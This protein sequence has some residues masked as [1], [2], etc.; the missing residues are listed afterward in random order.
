[1][2]GVPRER[3][4]ISSAPSGSSSTPRI[5]R[6]PPQDRGELVGVVVV[7]AGD[8]AEAVAQRTGDEPGARGG[9]DEREARQVEAD[10]ARARALADHDVEAE[11]LHRGIE[12]L[13][14]DAR[15][16]VHLVD[17]QHVA[18]V[19]V[20]E[21][22][23][24]VAGPLERGTA[25]GLMRAPISF[26][27]IPASVVL[28]RPGGPASST[29]STACP[30]CLAA[31]EHDLEVL[32]QARLADELVETARPQRGLFGDLAGSASGLEQL[33]SHAQRPHRQQHRSA[34]R[35]SSSTVPSSRQLAEHVADLVG[36]VAE[37]DERVA[38]LG[39]RR[40]AGQ[41]RAS[42]ARSRSGTSSRAFRSTS[43]RCAVRLPTP[44]TST[45][46]VEVVVGQA[47]AQRRRRVHRQDRERELRADAARGDQRL[48]RVALVA[49]RE[50]EEHHRVVAHVQMRER[51]TRARPARA[52]GTARSGRARG[53]RRRR[54]RR[55][56]RR[57]DV[58]S[59]TVPRT[60]P[61]MHG[62][63]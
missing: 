53:S 42:R 29:W 27:M 61:I 20:R 11:V 38:H 1:M 25:R 54:P 6:D 32:A 10:R 35:S 43:S 22:R 34:S 28:P 16:P 23:G 30:R 47:A 60:E 9:A 57:S 63:S 59:S 62:R 3:L 12:D 14:D 50:A 26:A 4:A 45:S 56:P 58:R 18:V 2:R 13:L 17:E 21:D 48:E 55:A 39:A 5:V 19:E 31:V 15:Q 46:D 52:A 24:E 7:E 44:G 8:E 41:S 40:S 33:L 37:A 51:G 36:A 49:R